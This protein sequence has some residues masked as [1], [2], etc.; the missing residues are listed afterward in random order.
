MLKPLFRIIILL[1][2]VVI[3]FS[4][5][6]CQNTSTLKPK[7]ILVTTPSQPVSAAVKQ[8]IKDTLFKAYY[9]K[10]K[11][12]MGEYGGYKIKVDSSGGFIRINYMGANDEPSFGPMTDIPSVNDF[13]E[14]DLNN[15]GYN[16]LVVCIPYNHGSRPRLDIYCYVTVNKKLKFYKLYSANQ[17]GICNNIK[18]DTSGR[19]FPSKI[20]KGYLIGQTDCLQSGDPGSCPSLEMISYFKFNKGLQFAKQERKKQEGKED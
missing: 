5:S 13:L 6:Q 20:E 10:Y 19:F 17:L 16:D 18:T 8:L 14:G 11:R 7:K 1:S 2:M 15:D 9:K 4:Q 3:T 12:E